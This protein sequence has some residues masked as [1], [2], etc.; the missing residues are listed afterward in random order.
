MPSLAALPAMPARHQP[1]RSCVACRRKRPQAELVRL[2]RSA[3]GEWQRSGK[4][5]R[6]RGAY[7]C[8]DSPE[9]W[10]EKRLR[11]TFGAS[12]ARLSQALGQELG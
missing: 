4:E 6:G 7:L 8:A 9:C 2:E 11:R 12:S 10:Q 5:R 1:E 3:S